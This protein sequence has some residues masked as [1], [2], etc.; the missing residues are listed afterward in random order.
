MSGSIPT[1]WSAST[2]RCDGRN[3][4]TP[5]DMLAV[6]TDI[7]SEMDQ[8]MGHRLAYAID[9]TTAWTSGCTRPPT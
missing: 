6:Q 7:Y 1:A 9:H 4:L 3:A 5:K 8:E 2:S